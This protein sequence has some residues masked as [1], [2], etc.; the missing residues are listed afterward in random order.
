ME[1]LAGLFSRFFGT[2]DLEKSDILAGLVLVGLLQGYQRRHKIEDALQRRDAMRRQMNAPASQNSVGSLHAAETCES[3]TPLE[4]CW[5]STQH[6]VDVYRDLY[7]LPDVPSEGSEPRQKNILGEDVSN[8]CKT[9]LPGRDLPDPLTDTEGPFRQWVTSILQGPSPYITPS[10]WAA[11][12]APG[13]STCALVG[14]D[15]R[16]AKG[17]EVAEAAHWARY[18]I[19]AYGGSAYIWTTTRAA[20]CCSGSYWRNRVCLA[21]KTRPRRSVLKAALPPVREKLTHDAKSLRDYVGTKEVLHIPDSDL[22]YCNFT[23]AA[24]G[25]TPYHIVLDRYCGGSA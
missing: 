20:W 23:D 19:A 5:K 24:L 14:G 4:Q 18:A 10:H 6:F 3:Q 13:V 17:E 7:A 22:V 9:H 2:V 12:L 1:E 16:R 15:P 21:V 8:C 25:T 11:A